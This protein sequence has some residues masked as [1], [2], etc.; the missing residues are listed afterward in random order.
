MLSPVPQFT[1]PE[2]SHAQKDEGWVQDHHRGLWGQAELS[3]KP[4]LNMFIAALGQN[5]RM[6]NEVVGGFPTAHFNCEV[7]SPSHAIGQTP[8]CCRLALLH[9][10]GVSPADFMSVFDI[11]V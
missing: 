1:Q 2:D 4:K 7:S 10:E 8:G 9:Q 5:P 11:D 3:L 6:R